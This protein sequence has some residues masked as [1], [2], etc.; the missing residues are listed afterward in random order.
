MFEL[1]VFHVNLFTYKACTKFPPPH[2]FFP[3]YRKKMKIFFIF[4][5]EYLFSWQI[6]VCFKGKKKNPLCYSLGCL[7]TLLRLIFC[8]CMCIFIFLPPA[9]S[10]FCCN[11][12][13]REISLLPVPHVSVLGRNCCCFRVLVPLRSLIIYYISSWIQAHY[14]ARFSPAHDIIPPLLR[15]LNYDFFFQVLYKQKYDA[16]K[17]TSDYAHMKEPPDIKH[18]ME[19]NKHQSDVSTPPSEICSFVLSLYI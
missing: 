3:E 17:G 12:R 13:L 15:S 8:F 4:V 2:L 19:V 11:S 5:C 6:H 10:Y 1:R 7:L 9:Y 16:E 14:N 18:A